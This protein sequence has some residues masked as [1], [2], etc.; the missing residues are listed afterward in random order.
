VQCN[1]SKGPGFLV[2]Q[3]RMHVAIDGAI[4]ITGVIPTSK[5]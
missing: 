3:K 1:H 5:S 2:N 4:P